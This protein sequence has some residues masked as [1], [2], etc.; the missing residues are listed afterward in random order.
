MLNELY[1]NNIT[2]FNDYLALPAKHIGT[3][4][5]CLVVHQSNAQASN[6]QT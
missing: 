4:E 6:T 3:V 5:A 2:L 1:L